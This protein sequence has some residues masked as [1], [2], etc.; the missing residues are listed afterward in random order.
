MSNAGE[1]PTNVG[2]PL[3]EGA[4]TVVAAPTS[5]DDPRKRTASE[6]Q[7]DEEHE[8]AAN[9]DAAVPHDEDGAVGEEEDPAKKRQRTSRRGKNVPPPKKLNNEQWD[10]NFEKLIEYK[11]EHGDCLVPKRYA[12]DPKLGTWVETQRV[13]YKKLQRSAT[14][15]DT[16]VTPNKRLNAERLK[17]LES[18]G[19]AWSAKNMRKPKQ[20]SPTLKKKS[21]SLSAAD[22]ASRAAA[23]NRH[24]DVQWNEMYEKLVKYK[25]KHGDCLVPKKF[26]EDPKLGTWVE[27]Q[28]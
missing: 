19:F 2:E 8:E 16:A 11:R 15:V 17:K 27:T 14:D 20:T 10:S 4:A 26:E 5:E 25:E 22:T 7:E 21:S 1:E 23:R 18:I 3:E 6:R 13:Q 24:N 12:A 28:R 9:H